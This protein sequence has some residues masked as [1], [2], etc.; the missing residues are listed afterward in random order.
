MAGHAQARAERK[1]PPSSWQIALIEPPKPD[2]QGEPQADP[3]QRAEYIG[4]MPEE[5][6]SAHADQVLEENMRFYHAEA[7]A[8]WC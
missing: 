5:D 4:P 6:K 7:H 8:R 1:K 3:Q 2:A